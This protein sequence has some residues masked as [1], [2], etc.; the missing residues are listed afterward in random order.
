LPSTIRAEA[1]FRVKKIVGLAAVRFR[2]KKIVGLAEV[3]LA[4]C[5]ILALTH[6]FEVGRQVVTQLLVFTI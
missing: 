1:R 2:V 3:R 4:E 5:F 6:N